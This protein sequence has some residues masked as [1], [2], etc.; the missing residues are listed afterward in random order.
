MASLNRKRGEETL[1][2]EERAMR[3]LLQHLT[4]EQRETFREGKGYFSLRGKYGTPIRIYTHESANALL[5][6]PGR[7]VN[8]RMG[9]SWNVFVEGGDYKNLPEPDELLTFKLQCELNERNAFVGCK[10]RVN[11]LGFE[12]EERQ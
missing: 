3:L 1:T 6:A 7:L 12:Q 11:T 10:Q 5:G 2:P 8:T 9:L 4:P